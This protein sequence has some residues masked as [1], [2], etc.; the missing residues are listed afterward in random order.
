MSR[1]S[2]LGRLKQRT[3]FETSLECTARPCR[4]RRKKE[5]EK[6]FC[7]LLSW[8]VIFYSKRSGHLHGLYYLVIRTLLVAS[9]QQSQSHGCYLVCGLHTHHWLLLRGL[10]QELPIPSI[11]FVSR[12]LRPWPGTFCSY[13][14]ALCCAL[15]TT[16]Y[17]FQGSSNIISPWLIS[18]S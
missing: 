8:T 3:K 16:S 5:E 1:V 4:R 11:S 12:L 6:S 2:V 15:L 17:V 13:L 9:P 10:T 14:L 7:L 18:S